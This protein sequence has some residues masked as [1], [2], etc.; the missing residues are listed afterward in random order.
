MLYENRDTSYREQAL[1][2][3]RMQQQHEYT[4][5]E[6]DPINWWS[7]RPGIK[8]RKA[9]FIGAPI[10][11]LALLLASIGLITLVSGILDSFSE[12][13]QLPGIVSGHTINSFDGLPRLNI[14]LHTADFPTIVSP[15]VSNA[16]YH[17]IRDGDHILADYS[18]RLHFPY[19]LE[20]AGQHYPIPGSSRGDDPPGSV[21]LLLLGAVLFPYPVL[22]VLWGWRDQHPGHNGTDG[23]CTM[24]AKIVG[25]R[26]AVRTVARR[27][28][29]LPGLL[30]QF[31]HS[32]YGVALDPIE[33]TAAQQIMTFSID[34]ET[35]RSLEEGTPVRI[36]Y[37]PHLHYVHALEKI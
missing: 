1:P 25:K 17:A 36:T 24:T 14:R 3:D 37:S 28:S 8:P 32:W 33:S 19:A 23:R 4:T 13:L 34:Y 16:A 29:N 5:H 2:G 9:M 20:S 27:G 11:I 7:W 31:S 21:A 22:L 30:P 6:Y 12:P 18:P 35:Y 26:A 15:V 10:A